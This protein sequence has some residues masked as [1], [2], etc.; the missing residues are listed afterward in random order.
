V[1]NSFELFS[2]YNHH[3]I[4]MTKC[5]LLICL[6]LCVCFC[7]TYGQNSTKPHFR[8]GATIA[9]GLTRIAD[10]NVGIGGIAAVERFFSSR[11]AGEIEASYTYFTGD[12]GV[13]PGGDNKAWTIPLLAGVKMYAKKWLYGSLR[14]GAICFLLN[15]E[16]STHI[17]AAYG[18]AAGMN[19][20]EKNNRLNIQLGYTSFRFNGDNRGYAT[21][22][23][24]IIIN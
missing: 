18:L 5:C 16:T 20:P 7:H 22:A 6:A 19:L 9:F 3:L 15:H 8:V 23:A 17:R 2:R 14:A 10:N 24:A 1:F 12:K 4:A 21:L 11:F 13:Y